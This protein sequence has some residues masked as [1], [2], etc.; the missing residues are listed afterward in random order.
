[1]IAIRAYHKA[2]AQLLQLDWPPF[3]EL[4][5]E[6]WHHTINRLM[7]SGNTERYKKCGFI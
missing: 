4:G 7:V 2:Y 5:R 6:V 3:W 1:M